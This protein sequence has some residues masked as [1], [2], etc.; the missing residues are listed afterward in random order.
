MNYV[1]LDDPEISTP[2]PS[3]PTTDS[4]PAIVTTNSDEHTEMSSL[5]SGEIDINFRDGLAGHCILS[6]LQQAAKDK[7]CMA[8]LNKRKETSKTFQDH[9]KEPKRITAGVIFNAGVVNLV[10]GGLIDIVKE[11]HKSKNKEVLQKI[12]KEIERFKKRK[13]KAMK[14]FEKYKQK[15]ISLRYPQEIPVDSLTAD[16]LKTLI[17][18]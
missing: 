18:A 16:D 9:I 6:L 12:E 10:K 2:E 17:I 7:Q 14:C 13:L 8:N 3:I 15:H 11:N 5:T 1:L 4:P